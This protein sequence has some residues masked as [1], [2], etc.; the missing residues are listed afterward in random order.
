MTKSVR[1]DA[2]PRVAAPVIVR[3]A[4]L[5]ANVM[6]PFRSQTCMQDI[7][8]L[9]CTENDLVSTRAEMEKQLYKK[10]HG[11]PAAVRR[12]LLSVKRDCYNNR[13]LLPHRH[14][15][16]WPTVQIAVPDVCDRI[17]ELENK[18]IVLKEKLHNIFQEERERQRQ[19]LLTFLDVENLMRGLAFASPNL[20]NNLR[21]LSKPS[22]SYGRKERRLEESLLRYVSRACLKL[23]PFSTLTRV[24]LGI[25][26]NE[27]EGHQVRILGGEWRHCHLRRVKRHIVNQCYA[28]LQLHP[29]FRGQLRIGMNRTIAKVGPT[30]YR[31]IHPGNWMF[32]PEAK[33]FRYR[34]DSLI[35]VELDGPL[36]EKLQETL[37]NSWIFD[38]L[39]KFLSKSLDQDPRDV[40]SSA[41]ALLDIGFLQFLCPWPTDAIDPDRKLLIF[42]RDLPNDS[43]LCEFAETL[44]RTLALKSRP[45]SSHSIPGALKEISAST[46]SGLRILSDSL[47]LSEPKMNTRRIVHEDV[48]LLPEIKGGSEEIAGISQ[49]SAEKAL[50]SARPLLL[51][52]DLNCLRYEYLLSLQAAAKK[53]WPKHTKI[54]FL[55]LF[56][57]AQPLW[58]DYMA[59]SFSAVRKL[60]FADWNPYDLEAILDLQQLRSTVNKAVAGCLRQEGK[61]FYF[62]RE[63]VWQ[64][65][66]RIPFCYR[67][68][69]GP[70]LFIQPAQQVGPDLW[71]LN[72]FLDGTGRFS[73]RYTAA[74]HREMRDR[75]TEHLISSGIVDIGGESAEL[76]D[77][78]CARND[79]LNVHAVQTPRVLE[80][81]G[82]V[83]NLPPNRRLRLL[84][85][86]IRLDG[87]FPV[88]VDR[89]GQRVLPVFLGGMALLKMPTLVKFLYHFS[90]A[91]FRLIYPQQPSRDQN[92]TKF[93]GRIRIGNL[94][95]RRRRWVISPA[96]LFDTYA[97]K[98]DAEFFLTMNRWRLAQDIP[99]Q[100]F[101]AEKVTLDFD[102]W[103]VYK[104]Q[105]ID[106]SSPS[107]VPIF[108]ASLE[109]CKTRLE[110]EEMLPTPDTFPVDGSGQRWAFEVQLESIVVN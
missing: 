101:V 96:E 26:S 80:L 10:I 99:E 70:C 37:S 24:A 77:I 58:R 3:I 76:V 34:E 4:G 61:D 92:G 25:V 72:H 100:V 102:L 75:Y 107:F 89:A 8:S 71:M 78:L 104:P 54:S 62:C 45:L 14:S 55:D 74:M 105:Y 40:K 91:E 81:P 28:L 66:S 36:I 29:R 1:Y 18:I 15:L 85:L 64:A 35:S 88:I 42:L 9:L 52:S 87:Q 53:R 22:L 67:P 56:Q 86:Y 94:I 59:A 5:P 108:R 20:Y 79:H 103:D 48:F 93:Y 21:H 23:S 44:E 33:E 90:Q 73:T 60:D 98:S 12:V 97:Y 83:S 106:F 6:E 84:D 110:L 57:H 50:D 13:S 30:N 69:F 11:A 49:L 39:I 63:E 51:Y 38:E 19:H 16:A 46:S 31:F 68:I 7:Y 47:R 95:L 2:S 17:C 41:E 43:V 109:T 32:D 65:L 82:E 27:N